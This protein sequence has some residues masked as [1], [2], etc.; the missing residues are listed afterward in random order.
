MPE[1]IVSE[2]V[3]YKQ[4]PTLSSYLAGD[5]GNIFS[6]HTGRFI[7][8][9]R[10]TDGYPQAVFCQDG[11]RISKPFHVVILEA[12]VGPQSPGQCARHLND[13]KDDNRL[14]NLCWGTYAENVADAKRNGTRYG[15]PGEKNGRS[16]LSNVQASEILKMKGTA[17]QQNV[18]ESFG[19]SRRTVGRIWRGTKWKVIQGVTDA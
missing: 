3:T 17:T 13:K 19:V 6:R 5:D 10:H 11:K 9:G 14:C 8:G 12:F 2:I 15:S 7:K 1:A 16:K 4:H 18:A